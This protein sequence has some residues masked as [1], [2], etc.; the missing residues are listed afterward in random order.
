MK[1][2]ILIYS[3][4]YFPELIG[5]GK[6]NTEMANWLVNEGYDVDVVCA[7][8]YYPSWELSPGFSGWRY[9]C[10]HY[11]LVSVHRCPVWLP[12]KLSGINRILHLFSFAISSAI[13]FI[14]LIFKKKISGVESII[15]L[16][17]PPIF[18]L[19]AVL[20][21]S[22]I[23]QFKVWLHVQ[24]FEIDAGFSLGLLPSF[25][26]L[27]VLVGSIENWLMQKVQVV[28]TISAQMSLR[29]YQKGVKL[30]KCVYFPNWVDCNAIHPINETNEYRAQLG[31]SE[32]KIVCLYSG[33]LG[34]KQGISILI[35][36]ARILECTEKIVFVIAGQGPM[37]RVL[38]EQARC[39]SNIYFL[40]L[41]PSE[42]FNALLNMADIHLLP[43]ASGVGD[44]V[45]PSKL[46]AMLA[47]GRPVIATAYPGTQ[48]F[49]IVQTCGVAVP[50]EEVQE[51]TKA[52]ADLA[53][54]H[55]K[56]QKLGSEGRK[57][58]LSHWDREQVL[59]QFESKL[60]KLIFTGK[61]VNQ[62]LDSEAQK[63]ITA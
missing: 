2:H 54:H 37:K 33:N 61:L 20:I 5:I 56:R 63:T 21:A 62:D 42:R 35:E 15:F 34:A 59:S 29:L 27:T 52:I 46:K 44:L 39:L 7:P 24:D 36:A 8:P 6:Y 30:D 12:K 19:P 10:N 13:Q 18:C 41:Q 4:N 17:E 47:S 11:G 16:V 57:Y 58:A 60:R 22:K 25:P 53:N 32:D 3:L 45:L 51:L 40:D 23:F 28:S 48:V 1:P 31:I 43:Q 55:Q 26:R 50:P 49:N 9:S 38:V 14:W